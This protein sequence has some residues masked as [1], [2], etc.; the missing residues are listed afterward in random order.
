MGFELTHYDSAVNSV[1]Y[2]A[3]NPPLPQMNEYTQIKMITTSL[4]AK[5]IVLNIISAHVVIFRWLF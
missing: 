2:Y 5:K 3:T 4:S 1:N